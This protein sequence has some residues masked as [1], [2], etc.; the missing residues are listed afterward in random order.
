MRLT[1]IRDF[2]AIANHRSL[3]AAAREIGI[4]QPSLT[5]SI[6]ALEREVGTALF[7]RTSRGAI[8]T[9]MGKLFRAR[10]QSIVEDLRR[11]KE[12]IR[13]LMDGDTGEVSMAMT[14]APVFLFLSRALGEFSRRFPSV[15]VQ[16][17]NGTLPTYAHELRNG[18]LDFAI[19]PRPTAELDEEFVVEHLLVNPILPTCRR[20]HPAAA[21]A[22]I[23]ELLDHTWLA[24]TVDPSPR[25]SFENA[26][27][28]HG[29]DP[30]RRVVFC[31]GMATCELLRNYDAICWLPSAWLDSDLMGNWATHIPVREAYPR[32]SDLCLVRR[33]NFPLTPAADHLATLIRRLSSYREPPGSV[34]SA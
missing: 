31:E 34:A 11:A 27:T 10:T 25:V 33:R 21:A 20:D 29:F 28:S 9:P 30:P 16:I 23:G 12:E 1:Q 8:L 14:P 13:Q 3:R 7:E 32:Q 2:L 26:F 22:S 6:Q 24:T 4:A 15:T 18:R 5:K 17:L 19:V